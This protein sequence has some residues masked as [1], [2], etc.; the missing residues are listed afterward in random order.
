MCICFIIIIIIP[1]P[2]QPTGKDPLP[3]RKAEAV[4]VS[5]NSWR[6]HE[7]HVPSNIRN[8]F[9][10]HWVI[11]LL[12]TVSTQDRA[13][14]LRGFSRNPLQQSW[15]KQIQN[16][17]TRTWF[18]RGPQEHHTSICNCPAFKEEPIGRQTRESWFVQWRPDSGETDQTPGFKAE[19]NQL[20]N[21]WKTSDGRIAC[22]EKQS[23]V[24][25]T[26]ERP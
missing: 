6:F 17:F 22:G 20:W 16:I 11:N 24:K 10:D 19:T 5:Q 25:A 21:E 2:I 3:H 14:S 12:T 18:R 7:V 15:E 9:D 26:G 23:G 1:I 13:W 4:W 8:L